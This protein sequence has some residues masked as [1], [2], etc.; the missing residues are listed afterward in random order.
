MGNGGSNLNDIIFWGGQNEEKV[1]GGIKWDHDIQIYL[2]M[3]EP[4]RPLKDYETVIKILTGKDLDDIQKTEI[5]DGAFEYKSNGLTIE[6]CQQWECTI[7]KVWGEGLNYD[8]I[9]QKLTAAGARQKTPSIEVVMPDRPTLMS[10]EQVDKVRFDYIDETRQK[11]NDKS[12]IKG[13][14]LVISNITAIVVFLGVVGFILYQ[15]LVTRFVE[16]PLPSEA[17]VGIKGDIVGF[18]LADIEETPLEKMG[19][20][21]GLVMLKFAD[22]VEALGVNETCRFFIPEGS[23]ISNKMVPSKVVDAEGNEIYDLGARTTEFVDIVDFEQ[24]NTNFFEVDAYQNRRK[25]EG[26]WSQYGELAKGNATRIILRGGIIEK[27]SMHVMGLA[28]GYVKLG[29][30]G[31]EGVNFYDNLGDN[32]SFVAAQYALKTKNSVRVFGQIESTFGT[33][34]GRNPNDRMFFTF[35]TSFVRSR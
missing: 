18:A 7:A 19:F 20:R 14:S 9:S 27:D 25:S 15:V 26:D 2:S 10:Q 6:V 12:R 11:D 31:E 23:Q 32:Q 5:F 21:A 35:R 16:L 33:K 30:I 13:I 8:E 22:D 34:E 1:S 4:C 28:R 17:F 24:V 29:D 3:A